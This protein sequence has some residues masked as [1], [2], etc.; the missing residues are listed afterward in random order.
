MSFNTKPSTI[1]EINSWVNKRRTNAVYQLKQTNPSDPLYQYLLERIAYFDTYIDA[2]NN[3][4]GKKLP[5]KP[6]DRWK[7]AKKS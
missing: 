7:T 2:R 1:A 5:T 6:R 3:L 4:V